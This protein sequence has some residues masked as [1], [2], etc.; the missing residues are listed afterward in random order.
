MALYS[1]ETKL[2]SLLT[3]LMH[4]TFLVILSTICLLVSVLNH[5]HLIIAQVVHLFKFLVLLPFL[6][7][8]LLCGIPLME[9]SLIQK[10]LKVLV[11]FKLMLALT[12]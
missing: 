1:V 2:H 3:R 6:M 12:L 7:I 10:S 11:M 8:T 4:L 9:N 5:L